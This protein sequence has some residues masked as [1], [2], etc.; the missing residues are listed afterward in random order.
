MSGNIKATFKYIDSVNIIDTEFLY[1][2]YNM[3]LYG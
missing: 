3:Y 2:Y 1:F